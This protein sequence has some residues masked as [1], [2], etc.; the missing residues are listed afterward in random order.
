MPPQDLFPVMYLAYVVAGAGFLLMVSVVL[1]WLVLAQVRHGSA[2][3]KLFGQEII[4][5]LVP[6]LVFVG[7]TV[8]GEIPRGWVRFAAGTASAEMQVRLR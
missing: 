7:L 5:T 4:W 2:P 8:L 3:R 6:A 1:I